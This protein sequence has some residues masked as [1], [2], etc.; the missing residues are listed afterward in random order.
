GLDNSCSLNACDV[1]GSG[2]IT[3]T[4]GVNILRAGAGLPAE[5]SCPAPSS[6]V[7][8]ARGVQIERMG[9]AGVNTAV[10]N[11]FFRESVESEKAAHETIVDAYKAESDPSK[12]PAFAAEMAGN[13]AILDSLDRNCGNQLLAGSSAT[14]GRY[15]AL[16]GVLADDQLYLNTASGTCQQYL[17]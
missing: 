10:T 14:A 11:P 6:T 2:S 5:S 1:D 8:A 9:R 16:A 7:R 17:A 15:D 4:D 3:V 13:L 12:W